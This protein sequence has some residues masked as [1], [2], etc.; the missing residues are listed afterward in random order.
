MNELEVQMLFH[1][2]TCSYW[3]NSPCT[4]TQPKAVVQY[5]ALLAEIDKLKMKVVELKR[6]KAE[7]LQNTEAM[8]E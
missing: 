1:A 6:F 2:R 4:C 3:I 8:N 5:S 7:L